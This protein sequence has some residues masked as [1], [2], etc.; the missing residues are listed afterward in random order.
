MTLTYAVDVCALGGW[1]GGFS[2]GTMRVIV[3]NLALSSVFQ[4]YPCHIFFSVQATRA[5]SY[6]NIIEQNGSIPWGKAFFFIDS[7]STLLLLLNEEL[8]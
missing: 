8:M 7:N 5:W 4:H 3:R 2:L 6:K 1:L